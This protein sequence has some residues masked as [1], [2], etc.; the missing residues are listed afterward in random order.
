MTETLVDELTTWVSQKRGMQAFSRKEYQAAF[1]AVR[2][3]VIEAV[4]AGF[5]LKTIWEHLRETGRIPFRY[6][7][8]LKHVSRHITDAPAGIPSSPQK[9][10]RK[11]DAEKVN[12]NKAG[13]REKRNP[14]SVGGF[15]FNS[16][17]S[18][19]DLC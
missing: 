8:F 4:A 7:T 3:D 16:N 19:E 9:K 10:P 1:L 11:K 17:P 6:E 18:P 5:A 12:A 14:P 13:G 15:S 2:A